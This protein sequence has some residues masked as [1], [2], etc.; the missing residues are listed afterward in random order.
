MSLYLQEISYVDNQSPGN[1]RDID[2][3]VLMM[4]LKATDLVLKKN[5]KE[6]VV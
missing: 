6:R 1:R 3:M 4:N 5:R 2:P